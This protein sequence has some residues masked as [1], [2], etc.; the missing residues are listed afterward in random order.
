MGVRGLIWLLVL[1]A[2]VDS[3]LFGLTDLDEGFYASVAWEMRQRGDWLTPTFQGEPWFEKPPLLYW[4]MMLSMRLF[5]ET[6]FALRVPSVLLYAL[7]LIVLGLWGNRRLGSGVGTWGALLFAVAP[8]SLLLA[9]LAIT[10]MALCFFLMLALIAL[11]EAPV[12]PWLWAP[13]G[14][15]AL[16]L[17]VLT[18]GPVGLGLVGL[19]YLWNARLLRQRGLKFRWVG[20][21]LVVAVAT[22]LPWYGG[23]YLKHGAD[24]FNE[25][26]VRQNLMRFAGGDTAHSVLSLMRSGHVGGFV[27]G[28]LAYLLF[29]VVVLALGGFPMVLGADA[30]WKGLEH[31]LRL[32][33]A[34]WVWVVFG[35][36][37][38]SFTKLPAYIFP[39]F[40]ALAL[41]VGAS[42]QDS[43]GSHGSEGG[44]SRRVR[45]A[46]LVLAIL[47]WGVASGFVGLQGGAAWAVALPVGLLLLSRG[48]RLGARQGWLLA[49]GVLG[50]AIGFNGV[51]VGYERIALKPVR[52]LALSAP[53]YR[54]LILYEVRPGYPSLLFYR[55]GKYAP[56]KDWQ[57]VLNR[58]QSEGAY[59]L[60]QNASVSQHP[61]VLIVGSAQVWGKTVYLLAPRYQPPYSSSSS[62][63]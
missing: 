59:C 3:A 27:G 24:F 60:T 34:R 41:L 17:A 54:T 9:R 14:G 48:A 23:V 32:Y 15:I 37:T 6:P 49:A 31:P 56:A 61:Q 10:D 7:T 63:R 16:G 22:C 26:V 21:A 25:F 36:F 11:W 30:L 50:L 33:L 1:M 40:P 19:L 29:Y 28:V 52:E 62:S 5:G 53:P 8:L 58:M 44:W 57:T 35:L 43:E 18:K 2:L 45:G 13:L 51:L 39:M 12:R 20:V 47:T 4:L 42:L 46:V 38:L 55:R